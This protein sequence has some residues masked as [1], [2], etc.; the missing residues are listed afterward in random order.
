VRKIQ[1]GLDSMAAWCKRRNIKISEDE[2]RAIYF[3][4][5]S[6]ALYSLLT[7]NGQNIPFVNSIKYLAV[8]IDKRMTWRLHIE[9]IEPKAFITFI[10]IYSLYKSE[11]FSAN[12]ILRFPKP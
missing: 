8:I 10:R 7:L 3:A 1:H 6:R 2:T 12:L 4:H 9:M 5:R 11:R